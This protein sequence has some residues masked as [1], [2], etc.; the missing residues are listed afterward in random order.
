MPITILNRWFASYV[1]FVIFFFY[2]LVHIFL[3]RK[4]ETYGRWW[5]TYVNERE[6]TEQKKKYQIIAL[7]ISILFHFSFFLF[8]AFLSII[9][10]S[11]QLK[12][13]WYVSMSDLYYTL[14]MLSLSFLFWK[15]KKNHFYIFNSACFVSSMS[16]LKYASS[17]LFHSVHF[18]FS[19]IFPFLHS[20]YIKWQKDKKIIK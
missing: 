15:K 14:Q 3:L 6:T 8:F 9:D 16:T 13:C 19:F 17:W 11:S 1:R 5:P 12:W 10:T 4:K 18:L 2:N 20:I 7:D